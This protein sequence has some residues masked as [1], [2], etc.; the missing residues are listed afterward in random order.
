MS[1]ARLEN[2]HLICWET[3]LFVVA[4][5]ALKQAFAQIGGWRG[6]L[7]KAGQGLEIG[8]GKLSCHLRDLKAKVLEGNNTVPADENSKKRKSQ[9]ERYM[10]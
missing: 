2:R 4:V 6:R 1:G 7:T 3:H 5:D 9:E 8:R 10:G